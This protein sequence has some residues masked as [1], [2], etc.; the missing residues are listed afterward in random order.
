[1]LVCLEWF[2]RAWGGISH[3][4]FDVFMHLDDFADASKGIGNRLIEYLRSGNATVA[5]VNDDRRNTHR[6]KILHQANDG[7][8]PPCFYDFEIR[9]DLKVALFR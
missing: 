9:D 5:V 2:L 7:R 6:Y 3:F 4:V 1:M 8:F